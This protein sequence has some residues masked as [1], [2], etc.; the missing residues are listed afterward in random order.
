LSLVAGVG[1]ESLQRKFT[2]KPKRPVP[3]PAPII[4]FQDYSKAMTPIER[5]R[6]HYLLF[7]YWND[8]LL[9]ALRELSPNPKRIARASE[10]SL[11]E[12]KTLHSLLNE[13]TAQRFE[14][15]VDER[16][17]VHQQV[18]RH[19]SPE[20]NIAIRRGLEQQ[21]RTIRREWFWRRIEDSLTSE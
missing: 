9:D 21:T 7:T 13:E 15:L 19:Y 18:Q 2:R 10:E 5:Y 11:N 3:P 12:L 16:T 8:N 17:R 20:R 6:K 1:C 14:P 4:N